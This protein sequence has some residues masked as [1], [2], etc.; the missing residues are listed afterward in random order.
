MKRIRRYGAL[1]LSLP[2]WGLLG[3]A[4]CSSA[5]GPASHATAGKDTPPAATQPAATPAKTV[6]ATAD[7]AFNPESKDL[8]PNP[9]NLPRVAAQFWNYYPTRTV[10][11]VPGFDPKPEDTGL[12]EYGGLKTRPL[13]RP[14]GFFRVQRDADRWWFVD[15]LGNAFVNMA[16]V[17][18]S[19]Y[20][21][22]STQATLKAKFG[23]NAQWAAKTTDWLRELG[24]NG[25]GAWSSVEPLRKAP[26]PL[27]Y[28][29]VWNFMS[30]YGKKRGGTSS[31]P[32]HTGYPKDCIFVFDPAFE[33]FCDEFA[34]KLEATKDDPNLLGHFTDNELPFPP[35][36]LDKYLSLPEGDAGRLFAEKW[37]A[38]QKQAGTIGEGGGMV[39]ARKAFLELM[40]RRYFDV[41]TKA[42][43]KVDPNHLILGCRFL[44]YSAPNAP[45]FRAA[46]AGGVDVVSVNY[47]NAW[48]PAPKALDSWAAWSGRPILI[49]EWYVKG[50]DTGLAN[51]S[52]AGWNVKN[53][54]D[55]GR[56]YQNFT[57]GLLKSKNCVG[58]QWF[59]YKDNDPTDLKTDASNRD[60]NKGIVSIQYEP[61]E[62]LT[63]RMSQLNHRAYRL[64]E[65]YDGQAER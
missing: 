57:L 30:G 46:G 43:R 60:S 42:I 16:V 58:W 12:D 6:S 20:S 63:S 33:T 23:D 5:S 49:T 59:M 50:E 24:F 34:K 22:T 40:A 54:T 53:Q 38:E 4:A 29:P 25:T 3:L 19:P 2:L 52:G 10:D 26:K 32:G 21:T 44:T 55:R 8:P 18:V 35:D 15:P 37:V 14:T 39:S 65:H 13:A 47:Y 36:A 1:L 56:F 45:V 17:S 31:Q 61:Y 28:T 48:T 11:L 51:K 9:D 27:T 7:E 41:T 62:S 64:I